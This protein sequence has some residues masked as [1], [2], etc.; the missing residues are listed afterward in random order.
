MIEITHN[1]IQILGTLNRSNISNGKYPNLV[2]VN[3]SVV[4]FHPY[5]HLSI[6]GQENC[7]QLSH[8][9]ARENPWLVPNYLL[10]VWLLDNTKLPQYYSVH[11]YIS[12]QYTIFS[13]PKIKWRWFY[14]YSLIGTLPATCCTVQ[15]VDEPHT[16]PVLRRLCR[17]H[18]VLKQNKIVTTFGIQ[19]AYKLVLRKKMKRREQHPENT[20]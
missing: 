1:F 15:V 10:W 4:V 13:N 5:P 7:Q 16:T 17:K 11:P 18:V 3:S 2:D 12:C 9:N 8:V 6:T 19:V 14:Y 20:D